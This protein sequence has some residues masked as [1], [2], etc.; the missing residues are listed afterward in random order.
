M[1]VRLI[2]D[3]T[4]EAAH[5]LPRAPEGHKCRRLHGHSFRLEIAVEGE[6]DPETGWFLDYGV[7]ASKV[8]P[9]RALLDHHYL[10]EV[11]GLEN[12]TSENLARWMRLARSQ[13][14]FRARRFLR[15]RAARRNALANH[16][17]A[18]ARQL[19]QR[20]T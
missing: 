14:N 17:A 10:N 19:A 11:P 8:E 5:L 6:V 15:L 9:I 12:A 7:I 3:F 13:R 20:C 2:K 18:A 16:R 4:F 1:R